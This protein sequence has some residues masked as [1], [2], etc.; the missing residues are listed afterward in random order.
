MLHSHDVDAIISDVTSLTT[1]DDPAVVELAL[2]EVGNLLKAISCLVEVIRH[3]R[4][5]L[6]VVNARVLRVVMVS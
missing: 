3:L 4:K 2:R 5:T 6:G 1:K